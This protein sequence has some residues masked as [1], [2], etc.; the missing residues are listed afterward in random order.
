MPT[1]ALTSDHGE[2]FWEHGTR[3][4][5]KTLFEETLRVPLILRYPP[6][7]EAGRR[8]DRPVQGVDIVP[9]LLE[10]AGVPIPAA[11]DGHSLLS[12]SSEGDRLTFSSLQLQDHRLE[13]VRDE[14]WK[15][16]WNP[17]RQRGSL[18]DLQHS[19]F[20]S[21]DVAGAHPDVVERMKA[22][23]ARHRDRVRDRYDALHP[24]TE[25]PS[26]GETE[27]PSEE[28]ELLK[29]LGYIDDE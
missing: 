2:E 10:L 13:A 26:V 25:S 5:G 16:I 29:H 7:V 8:V 21:D 3:G 23:L 22:S 28:R 14:A 18:Y 1:V 9:T 19:D 17:D 6:A 24:S 12:S 15:W 20:E 27:I 4:H 11:V